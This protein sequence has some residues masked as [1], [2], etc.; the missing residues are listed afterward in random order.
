MECENVAQKVLL[1]IESVLHYAK[2]L[3]HARFYFAVCDLK[4]IGHGNPDNNLESHSTTS[5]GR[6]SNE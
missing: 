2:Q 6:I 5:T 4:I 3:Q 1:I